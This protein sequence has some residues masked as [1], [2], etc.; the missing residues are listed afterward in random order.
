MG[1]PCSTKLCVQSNPLNVLEMVQGMDTMSSSFSPSLVSP[2]QEGGDWADQTHGEGHGK[3]DVSLEGG[4]PCPSCSL[5]PKCLPWRQSLTS[6]NKKE[7]FKRI[8]S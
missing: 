8:H 6:L 2:V 5:M 4:H 3:E 1:F 7:I